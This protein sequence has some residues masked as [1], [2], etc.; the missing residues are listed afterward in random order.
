MRLISRRGLDLA[1]S[2]AIA[3]GLLGAAAGD[4]PDIYLF[5]QAASLKEEQARPAL[6]ALATAWKDGYAGPLIDLAGLLRWPPRPEASGDDVPPIDESEEFPRGRP[7]PST[8]VRLRLTRFL[9][10]QTRQPH[11][12]DLHA[13]RRWLWSLPYDPHPDYAQFKAALYANVDPRMASFF[14]AGVRSLVRLDEVDWGGV[15]VNGIPPLDHPPRARAAEARWLKDKDIVFGIALGAEARAYPQ[16]ILGWHELARDRLGGVELTI[17]YCTLCGTVIPYA[18]EA[19][20]RRHTFGTSGLLY[21]SNK[22]LFDEETMSLWS[23]LEGRPVIGALAGSGLEL[24]A[25]PVVTTTWRE[26]QSAHPDT[27]WPWRCRFR[28]WKTIPSTGWPSQAT[29][30]SS[31]PAAAGRTVCTTRA[32]PLSRG[33]GRTGSW[34]TRPGGSGARPR[35]HS[36]TTKPASGVP[37]CPPAA[38][39]GLAGTPSSP[40]PCSSSS[41]HQRCP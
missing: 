35:R 9:T 12:N 24:T 22:L 28:F 31:S 33:C 29:T 40:T 38:P 32:A 36:S 4:V 37:V 3:L 30:W 14:P 41:I 2:P 6:D 27:T 10:K 8:L 25:Y 11:G 20:G 16:C 15:R 13:W 26:W 18:S 19:G 7:H 17:V 5:Y 34:K 21:R 39:S 23:T 1:A